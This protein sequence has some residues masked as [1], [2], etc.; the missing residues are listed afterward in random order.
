MAL[1]FSFAEVSLPYKRTD[2]KD[3]RL[4]FVEGIFMLGVKVC[5][6][7]RVDIFI[8]ERDFN[9]NNYCQTKREK[10]R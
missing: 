1:L 2:E 9:I 5:G 7:E 4:D 3:F 8:A 10:H 6:D